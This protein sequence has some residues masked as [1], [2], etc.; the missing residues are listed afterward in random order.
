MGS[1][2]SEFESGGIGRPGR[3]LLI[4]LLPAALL[5]ILAA[6]VIIVG[7]RGNDVPAGSTS[8]VEATTGGFYVEPFVEPYVGLSSRVQA[9]LIASAV[10][11]DR[12][13]FEESA[14]SVRLGVNPESMAPADLAA[15]RTLSAE[16]SVDASTAINSGAD[17]AGA[18]D[19]FYT[20][21]YWKMA[22]E[23]MRAEPPAIQS[24]ADLAE[25]V[26]AYYTERYWKMAAESP[27][28]DPEEDVP[29]RHPRRQHAR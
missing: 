2:L 11:A 4:V 19:A 9:A 10:L 29:V 5:L 7:N 8:A 28:V 25:E 26:D 14:I 16:S 27:A 15:A 18:A 3:G 21:R 20:E 6:A 17:L 1:R 23:S 22:A 13:F 24:G 12:K